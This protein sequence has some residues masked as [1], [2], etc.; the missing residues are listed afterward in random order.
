[1]SDLRGVLIKFK[2]AKGLTQKEM[3]EYFDIGYRTYQEIEKTGVVKKTEDYNKIRHKLVIA[4]FSADDLKDPETST[5]SY[6]SK[7]RTQ[8]NNHTK[9][10]IAVFESAPKT[11][12]TTEVYR[13]EKQTEPDFWIT[14]PFL[15]DCDYGCRAKGDSM[16]PIIRTNALVIG[17]RIMDIDVIIFGEIYI[18]KTKNNIETVKYIHPHPDNPDIVLLVPYND[19]AKSTPIHK[20]DILELHE[21]KAVFNNL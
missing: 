20:E 18:I 11:L 5:E 19:K 9:P 4:Q 13:D 15:R 1:M 8:K 17:K 16:H 21:A 6:I 10:S 3:S 7:R 14:I 2:A 12:T